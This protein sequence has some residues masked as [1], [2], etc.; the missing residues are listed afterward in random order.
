[1]CIRIK[2]LDR[3]H[4]ASNLKM[5]AR[6]GVKGYLP[7]NIRMDVGDRNTV[8]QVAVELG[9]AETGQCRRQGR[10]PFAAGSPEVLAGV[11]QRNAHRYR[12]RGV[13]EETNSRNA[14]PG[15]A[16]HVVHIHNL[17]IEQIRW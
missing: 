3:V 10:Y 7:N 16:V 12:F 6:T 17:R 11:F 14:A 5:Y 15:Q 1:M 9:S 8:D 2:E 4:D 13:I